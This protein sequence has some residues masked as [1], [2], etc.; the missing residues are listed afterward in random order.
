MSGWKLRL[1]ALGVFAGTIAAASG[2][3]AACWWMFKRQGSAGPAAVVA[4]PAEKPAP[5]PV[6]V[7]A[8]DDGSAAKVAELEKTL[9]ERDADLA[10]LREDMDK[11]RADR[12]AELARLRDELDKAK[13]R[14]AER[15][16]MVGELD[17][18]RGEREAELARL[19]GELSDRPKPDPLQ[20]ER[21]EM[22]LAERDAEIARLRRELEN[23]KAAPAPVVRN[24]EFGRGT[25]TTE[26][27]E[28]ITITVEDRILFDSGKADLKPEA[29][30]TLTRIAEHIRGKYAANS[31]EVVGH[32]DVEP[33]RNSGWQDN[34]HLSVGRS[35]AVLRFLTRAGVDPSRSKVS[36]RGEYAPVSPTDWAANR[37]VEIVIWLK[38]PRSVAAK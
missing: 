33:I 22:S 19:R 8:A 14:D 37:R 18:A 35:L 25:K 9:L 1:G 10:R 27:D 34:W 21:F 7:P 32:T 5:A 11:T 20:R 28:A 26:T 15:E 36:G 23:A 12:E 16:R 31:V 30:A 2:P 29:A 6:A 38:A 17:R 4:P 13:A 24:E 3:A